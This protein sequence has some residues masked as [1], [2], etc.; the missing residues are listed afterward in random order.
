MEALALQRPSKHRHQRGQA[1]R[2]AAA[3]R[4]HTDD[5]L[6]NRSI[7]LGNVFFR[8]GGDGFAGDCMVS[9]D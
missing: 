9:G 8:V 4:S 7:P 2:V 1:L 6:K 3:E 5:Q